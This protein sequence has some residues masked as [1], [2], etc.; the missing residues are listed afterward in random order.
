MQILE[1]LNSRAMPVIL[2]QLVVSTSSRYFD[3]GEKCLEYVL[4]GLFGQEYI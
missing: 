4:A 2:M 1:V 3:K